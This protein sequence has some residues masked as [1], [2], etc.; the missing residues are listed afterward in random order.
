MAGPQMAFEGLL[1]LAAFEADQDILRNGLFHRYGRCGLRGFPWL[2][3]DPDK[4]TVNGFDKLRQFFTRDLV[5]RH[6]CADY[7][8][9]KF[10]RF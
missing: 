10:K 6:V 9:C 7:V 4:H 8:R 2:T 5:V 1:L 3:P